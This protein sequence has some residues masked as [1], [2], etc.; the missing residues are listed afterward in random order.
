MTQ[1]QLT[2]SDFLTFRHCSKSL[3]LQ[4]RK[5]EAVIFPAPSLFDQLLM[6]DG[7]RVEAVVKE[8]VST[9]QDANSCQF[10]VTFQSLDGLFARADL[11][12]DCGGGEIDLYEIK[13]STSLKSS[14]GQDHIDDAAFQ[15]LVAERAGYKV[16]DVYVIHVQKDYVREG[17]INPARFLNIVNVTNESASRMAAIAR[18]A[19]AALKLL[20]MEAIDE[21]GCSCRRIGNTDNHCASFSYF[22]PDVPEKSVY[23]LPRISKARLDAFLSEGRMSLAEIEPT[24]LT[25]LQVPVLLA[26]KRDEPVVNIEGIKQFLNELTW[27]LHFYDYETFASAIPLS[28]GLKP[29]QKVP[30]QYSMHKLHRDG[31]LE[32][33]ESLTERPGEQ[34]QLLDRLMADCDLIGSLIAWNMSFEKSCN[35]TLAGLFPDAALFLQDLNARTVDLMDVFKEDYVDIRFKGSTSIKK[36]L[37]VI[38]PHLQYNEDAVH[39]GGGAMAAWLTMIE[40]DDDEARGRLSRELRAYCELDS[41]AMVE[42]FR[43]LNVLVDGQD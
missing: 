33:F 27:P 2:K 40:T 10:Q 39:D 38:C 8:L 6:Q 31:Q 19:D 17:S 12:R 23:L 37:P 22:N 9:W 32:H 25:R 11:V 20:A 29:Q 24:E 42:I 35:D 5:P 18:D 28:D 14:T 15:Q 30:V 34:R 4:K 1:M 3:W 21:R 43:F 16:R 7:Y 26:A 13:G 36:V 41:L